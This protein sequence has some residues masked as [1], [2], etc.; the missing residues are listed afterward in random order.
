MRKNEDQRL[1]L[2]VSEVACLLH[3]SKSKVYMLLGDR[4][5]DGI[6]VIRFGRS[7]RIRPNDLRRWIDEQ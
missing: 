2:T 1:L 3:M 5:P 7:L 4:H 6:P